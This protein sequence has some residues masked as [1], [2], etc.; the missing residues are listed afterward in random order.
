MVKSNKEKREELKNL[1]E[2]SKSLEDHMK[3]CKAESEETIKRIKELEKT[4]FREIS[5]DEAPRAG[6]AWVKFERE[7]C[8]DKFGDLIYD[9]AQKTGRSTLAIRY[10]LL[11]LI[12]KQLP[13]DTV[14]EKVT[15]MIRK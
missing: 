2:H 4:L 5:D 3:N 15:V 7:I 8:E 9:L 14:I 12:V 10:K 13:A 11:S 1:K 6:H